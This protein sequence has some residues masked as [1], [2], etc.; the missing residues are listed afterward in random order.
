MHCQHCERLC[1]GR[2]KKFLKRM[3]MQSPLHFLCYGARSWTH[4]V[5]AVIS[6]YEWDG[7]GDHQWRW[8]MNE[9]SLS[10]VGIVRVPVSDPMC[11]PRPKPNGQ[12]LLCLS[13]IMERGTLATTTFR[14]L[15]EWRLMGHT[16]VPLN[17]AISGGL[18]HDCSTGRRARM[19]APPPMC[20]RLL[21]LECPRARR[22]DCPPEECGGHCEVRSH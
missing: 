20:W 15:V 2:I 12:I 7:T 13:E 19:I 11:S 10:S 21:S 22:R 18:E 14:T 3:R 1:N 16:M 17:Q 5:L 9:P 8:T 4:C 6:T